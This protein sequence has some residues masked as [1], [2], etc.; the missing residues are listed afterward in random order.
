MAFMYEGLHHKDTMG[1]L[2]TALAGGTQWTLVQVRNT[3]VVV[4]GI[5]DN[6]IFSYNM[7]FNHD[8]KLGSVLDDFHI[9]YMFE[10]ANTGTCTFTWA[11]GWFK[12]DADPTK[13]DV[14]PD[15]LPNTGVT[16]WT[17]DG[18]QQ[19]KHMLKQIITGLTFDSPNGDETYSSMFFIKITRSA[20]TG[21]IGT[22]RL[23]SADCHYITDREGSKNVASD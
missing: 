21:S 1:F 8:K 6:D 22:M 15:T 10:S 4:P 5:A 16:T 23:L 20:S 12:F 17:I 9:H 13:C 2:Q 14:I 3:G 7:Q 19:Y 18:A 11:W